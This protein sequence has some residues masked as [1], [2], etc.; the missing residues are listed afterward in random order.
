[1]PPTSRLLFLVTILCAVLVGLV[2]FW[3]AV[4]PQRLAATLSASIERRTGLHLTHG[5]SG[6]ALSGGLTVYLSDVTLFDPLSQG[7]PAAQVDRVIARVPPF[8]LLGASSEP[9]DVI[10]ERPAFNLRSQAAGTTTSGAGSSDDTPSVKQQKP[11]SVTIANGSLKWDDPGWQE[12]FA[13]TDMN[14]RFRLEEDGSATVQAKALYGGK[15]TQADLSIEH[16]PKLRREGSPADLVLTSG[17]NLLA[18]NGRAVVG[19]GLALDGRVSA[20]SSRLQPLLNWLGIDL[21]GFAAAGKTEFESAL[22]LQASGAVLKQ[23]RLQADDAVVTGDLS[24]DFSRQRPAVVATLKATTLDLA[25]YSKPKADAPSA[26]RPAL[27]EP[28]QE[29]QWQFDD[30]SKLDA[31]IDLT[32]DKLVVAGLEGRKASASLQLHDG[33]L[34]LTLAS[35]GVAGGMAKAELALQRQDGAPALTLKLDASKVDARE[36]LK[37]LT[38]FSALQGPM[39]LKAD[40]AAEGDSAARLISTLSGSVEA[41]LDN[42]KI[43]GLDLALFL[44][45][46]SKGWALAEGKFTALAQAQ[47]RFTLAD[48]IAQVDSL[49]ADAGPLS[50]RAEGEIDLLRQNLDL[51]CKPTLPGAH[52]LPVHLAVTGPW[53][54]PDVATDIDPAKLKPKALLKSG[55]KAIKK[56]FGN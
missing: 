40:L 12:S 46:K 35:D 32:A 8:A 11:V 6:I 15:L 38:G 21:K 44:A 28:W 51:A 41:G 4:L 26:T 43:D 56:L 2:M 36:F 23:A 45:G 54:D 18:F 31:T 49:T 52:K 17:E 10:L 24:F 25:K 39:T 37:P 7:T 9:A 19:H 16:F 30:L 33:K 20:S 42:G 55:K 14:G 13:L 3:L 34:D 22:S 53:Q 29:A 48:G 27:T 50:V 5:A 1:M 47:G